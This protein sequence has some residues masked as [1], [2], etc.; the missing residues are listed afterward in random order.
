MCVH[1]PGCNN[2]TSGIN[3]APVQPVT[4]LRNHTIFDSHIHIRQLAPRGIHRDQMADVFDHSSCHWASPQKKNGSP[5][6]RFRSFKSLLLGLVYVK[7]IPKTSP[8]CRAQCRLHLRR[9]AEWAKQNNFQIPATA[10][11]ISR[12]NRH[13]SRLKATNCTLC[14]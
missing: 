7:R 12:C 6:H 10:R 8:A 1:Q 2:A 13:A 11:N 9:T 3:S 14:I 4:D 5:S